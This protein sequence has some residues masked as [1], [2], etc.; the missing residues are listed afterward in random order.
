MH[1]TKCTGTGDQNS[2]GKCGKKRKN[3]RMGMGLWECNWIEW[4]LR[5]NVE[6]NVFCEFGVYDNIRVGKTTGVVMECG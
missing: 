5:K 2:V 3:K 1:G 6:R 4:K